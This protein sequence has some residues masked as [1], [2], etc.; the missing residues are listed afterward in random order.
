MVQTALTHPAQSMNPPP[1]GHGQLSFVVS[2]Y[3]RGYW[4]LHPVSRL[5]G[6]W[7]RHCGAVGLCECGA[8]ASVRSVAPHRQPDA[9]HH[10]HTATCS[11][12]QHVR[13]PR[14]KGTT[15][16][17]N[18]A[19]AHKGRLSTGGGRACQ[20]H[21]FELG[22]KKAPGLLNGDLPHFHGPFSDLS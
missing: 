16:G 20:F 22:D 8:V 5:W 3:F 2:V 13:T 7:L 9:P 18:A 4:V 1:L 11:A 19:R 14:H 10:R 6:C 17:S 12:L 21:P 15:L